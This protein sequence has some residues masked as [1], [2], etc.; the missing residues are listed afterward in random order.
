MWARNWRRV[1]EA[2][3]VL[4][5][6]KDRTGDTIPSDTDQAVFDLKAA[7][8]TAMDEDLSLHRFWP[9]LFR[10]TKLVN[11]WATDK[12]FSGAAALI[13]LEE[14]LAVDEILGI[15]DQSQMPVPLSDLPAEVQGMLADRQKAREAKDFA[16]S[17][18]LRDSIVQAG[19]RLE[20]TGGVP[21][22]FKG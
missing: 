8:K 19:F 6:A 22:V 1:Q 20:D 11:G 13:C 10:F 12:S 18:A 3:A 14:L 7:F 21:R 2:A 17:D 16:A 9:T 15:L 4:T 5:L